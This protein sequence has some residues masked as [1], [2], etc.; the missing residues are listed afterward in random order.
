MIMMM[1]EKKIMNESMQHQYL[2]DST[3]SKVSLTGV[4]I[5]PPG[6]AYT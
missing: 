1:M 3:S 4:P 2:S 5:L 6:C